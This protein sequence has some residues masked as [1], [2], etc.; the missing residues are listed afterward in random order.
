MPEKCAKGR[1]LTIAHSR[2]EVRFKRKGRPEK[3]WVMCSRKER[4]IEEAAK[5]DAVVIVATVETGEG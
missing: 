3:S 5:A 2:V 4:P 1:H